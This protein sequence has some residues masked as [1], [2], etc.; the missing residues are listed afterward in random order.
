MKREH[1][2]YLVIALSVLIYVGYRFYQNQLLELKTEALEVQKNEYQ[3]KQKQSLDSTS[4]IIKDLE[5]K[6]TKEINKPA[7][8]IPRYNEKIIYISVT[9]SAF[10]NALSSERSKYIKKQKRQLGTRSNNH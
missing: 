10:Y 5:N 6:L 8:I 3:Q 4:S 9:D 1:L 7:V 2:I